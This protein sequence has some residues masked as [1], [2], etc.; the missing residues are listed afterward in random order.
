VTEYAALKPA[1]ALRADVRRLRR[2]DARRAAPPPELPLLYREE[3]VKAII[4][5]DKT[6]TRRPLQPQPVVQGVV[7]DAGRWGEAV[8][9]WLWRSPRLDAGLCHTDAPSMARLAAKASRYAPGTR[10]WVRE[11]FSVLGNRCKG[12]RFVSGHGHVRY[13]ATWDKAH[14]S[15]WRPSIHMPRWA[16]R[17]FLVVKSV[18]VERVQDIDQ[19]SVI[20][21]GV[22]I[23][24]TKE[25][26][27]PGMVCPLVRIGPDG[28]LPYLP[29]D[30]KIGEWKIEDIYRA[31]YAVLW[32]KIYGK[33]SALGWK[34]NP[35]VEVIQHDL[36]EHLK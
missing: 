30:A 7:R 17:L 31:E 34:A 11:T 10:I 19:K 27:E 18:R 14:G 3:M 20:A 26:C 36:V 8:P 21:E 22:S 1:P 16:A 29:K 35:W 33:D 5:G 24:V 13:R 32:D 25:G 15:V 23:P 12:E 2:L 9:A 6:E 4:A 28:L